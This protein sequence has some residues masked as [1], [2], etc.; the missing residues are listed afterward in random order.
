M[1]ANG[2]EAHHDCITASPDAD[3][4]EELHEWGVAVLI[5][6]GDDDRIV[7]IAAA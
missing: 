1:T 2:I 3:F 4:T 5:T 6:C 7:R